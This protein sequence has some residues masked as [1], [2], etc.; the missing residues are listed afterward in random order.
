MKDRKSPIDELIEELNPN[1]LF[2]EFL[3]TPE[4]MFDKPIPP[5]RLFKE[6]F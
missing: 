4:E 2:D 1:N 5:H 6:M 3:P